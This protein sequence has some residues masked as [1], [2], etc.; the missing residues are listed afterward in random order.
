MNT[1]EGAIP[2]GDFM[3]FV[4][5]PKGERT[6]I[7]RTADVASFVTPRT[8]F[9]RNDGGTFDEAPVIIPKSPEHR[10]LPA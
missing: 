7:E 1:V 3:A 5:M 8:V 9:I 4:S 2:T 10:N 6:P